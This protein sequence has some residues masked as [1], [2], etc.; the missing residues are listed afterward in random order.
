MT[1]ARE[2]VGWPVGC[3]NVAATTD[4]TSAPASSTAASRICPCRPI[5]IRRVSDNGLYDAR[6]THASATEFQPTPA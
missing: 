3:R 1:A 5:R 2:A 4:P 6:M